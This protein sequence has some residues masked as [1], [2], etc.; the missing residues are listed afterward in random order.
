MVGI[1]IVTFCETLLTPSNFFSNLF[2]PTYSDT[3]VDGMSR[4]SASSKM[5]KPLHSRM[6][7]V[8]QMSSPMMSMSSTRGGGGGGRGRFDSSAD[9]SLPSGETPMT[10][11]QEAH[12]VNFSLSI[13][14]IAVK[15]GQR[16]RWNQ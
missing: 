12:H 10:C 13:G 4:V 7:I 14:N 3:S 6:S 1:V 16:I 8:M 5:S 11:G 15:F 9:M 2:Q